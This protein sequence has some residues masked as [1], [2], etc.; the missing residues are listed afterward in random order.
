MSTQMDGR[1]G[2]LKI[3]QKMNRYL[4]QPSSTHPSGWVLTDTKNGIV[5]TFADGRFNDTQKVTV[6][7]DMPAPSATEFA[8]IMSEIR[9]WVARHH[10]SKCFRQP[11]GFEY[12]EDNTTLYLYR[13]TPP[14]WRMEILDAEV[15]PRR[16]TSSLRKAAEFLTK[17]NCN[18][19]R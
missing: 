10:G 15:S 11:Y 14:R 1:I 2:C 5:L 8:R 17:R 7:N 6:L 9:D 16:L 3:T 4:L 12:S 19:E 18:Y 13:R